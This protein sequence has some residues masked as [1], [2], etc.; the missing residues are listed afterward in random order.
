VT[1]EHLEKVLAY[2]GLGHAVDAK[3]LTGGARLTD[4]PLA[5]GN[6]L[7]PTVFAGVDSR[8]RI[9]QEEIFGPAQVI[10]PFGTAGEAIALAS[11]SRYGLAGMVWTS[12]LATARRV[13]REVRTGTMWVNCFFV[14]DLR[15]PFGGMKDSGVGREGGLYSAEFFTE[16]EAVV[17]QF[18]E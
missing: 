9:A 16:A 11:D 6:Y 17:L 7:A 4:G 1:A 15:A 18:P 5:A 8:W 3:L 12:S 14:R 13:A 10:A 2:V